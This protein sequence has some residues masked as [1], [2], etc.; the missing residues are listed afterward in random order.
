MIRL[1]N[2]DDSEAIA[3]LI[4][5][6]SD[7]IQ[8][9]NYIKKEILESTYSKYYVYEDNDKV[10]AVLNINIMNNYV[11]VIDLV[12]LEDYRNKHV[13][14]SLMNEVLNNI[15]FD[16]TLEVR[17]SNI[18]AIK[19]YEKLDFKTI[20]VRKNYYKNNGED[21]YIMLRESK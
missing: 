3:I 8:S 14:L 18:P 15:N 9:A 7:N 13:A 5:S 1:A 4:S 11:E 10:I 20:S 16:T 17:K 2:K 19:L 6:Y 12:V 21:A